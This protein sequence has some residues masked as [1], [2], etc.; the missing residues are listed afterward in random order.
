MSFRH[1]P[2]RH[3]LPVQGVFDVDGIAC[4]KG[5]P[6]AA[7]PAPS[8]TGYGQDVR[9]RIAQDRKCFIDDFVAHGQQCEQAARVAVS[10]IFDHQQTVFAALNNGAMGKIGFGLGRVVIVHEIGRF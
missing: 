8:R 1:E 4:R 6:N 2:S 10:A 3:W 5:P 7:H 9:Y